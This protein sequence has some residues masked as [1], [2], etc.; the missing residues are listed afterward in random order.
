LTRET[1]S[2]F[3]ARES[4]ARIEGEIDAVE[5]EIAGLETRSQEAADRGDAA[6]AGSLE[7]LLQSKRSRLDSLLRHR[8]HVKKAES[9][10]VLTDAEYERI[11]DAVR[12][13]RADLV[14]RREPDAMGSEI[15]RATAH[16]HRTRDWLRDLEFDHTPSDIPDEVTASVPLR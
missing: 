1:L 6:E 13:I 10:L 14:T 8:D 15:D 2:T 16:F 5:A 3:C 12:R 7:R 4:S 11:F 9:D